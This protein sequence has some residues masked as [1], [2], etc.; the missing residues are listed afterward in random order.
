MRKPRPFRL[1]ACS[2]ALAC[3]PA[4]ADD[5]LAPD[6]R[7]TDA[8]DS[9][10][11]NYTVQDN[12]EV[13]VT[14]QWNEDGRSQGVRVQSKTFSWKQNEFRDVYSI[15][16]KTDG[17]KLIEQALANRLLDESNA[18]TLGFWGKQDDTVYSIVRVPAKATPS[19]LHEAIS[20]AAEKADEMEKEIL[21]TDEY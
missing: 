7:V 10:D 6:K 5:K 20:F 4:L 19:Q 17:S 16:F 12:G 14:I 18:S 3:L 2:L 11:M 21:G 15:A 13:S 1:I 8:L 9:E